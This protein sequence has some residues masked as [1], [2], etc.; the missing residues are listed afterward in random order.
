VGDRGAEKRASGLVPELKPE[1]N[2]QSEQKLG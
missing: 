2:N 1:G